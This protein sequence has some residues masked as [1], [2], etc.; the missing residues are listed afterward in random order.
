MIERYIHAG[1]ELALII[2]G[3]FEKDG[4]EFFTP[5]HYSQQIGYM[6]RSKGHVI[7]AHVHNSVPRE[8]HYT[9]EVLFVRS[10]KLRVD[11]Y[12]DQCEYIESAVLEAGDI[13]LLASG[14]HGFEM[15]EE[16]EMIEVKQGPHAGEEDKTR[17][18]GVEP[19]DVRI[20]SRSK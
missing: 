15:I 2:R 14:G 8:V 10:G 19:S 3:N 4:I 12:S 18:E 13:I 16:T 9:R 6:K 11:L 5:D 1:I 17:F 7:P 20:M